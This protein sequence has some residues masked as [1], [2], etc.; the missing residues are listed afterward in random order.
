V[1]LSLL[2]ATVSHA[3]AQAGVWQEKGIPGV[4]TQS[5]YTSILTSPCVPH[6]RVHLI[7]IPASRQAPVPRSTA[8]SGVRAMDAANGLR[9]AACG[10][11]M[12]A[13]S[14]VAAALDDFVIHLPSIPHGRQPIGGVSARRCSAPGLQQLGVAGCAQHVGKMQMDPSAVRSI[15]RR[16]ASSRHTEHA[17]RTAGASQ[18]QNGTSG[19][20]S[21]LRG[22]TPQLRDIVSTD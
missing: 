21:G 20:M 17:P 4:T 19:G 15:R 7:A 2:L 6:L 11:L 5:V 18:M 22:Y 13:P 8:P 3:A 10:R 1:R 9:H 14:S 16:G 12:W